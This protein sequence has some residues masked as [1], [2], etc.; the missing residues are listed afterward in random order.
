MIRK[1][2]IASVVLA[3]ALAFTSPSHGQ[4]Y[5]SR[6]VTVVVPWSPGA[7]TDVLA[8]LV[9]EGLRQELGQPFIVD[10][11]AGASGAIGST[12]V[13]FAKPD[14]YTLLMTVS[15]PITTNQFFQKK[16]PF[17]PLKDVVP[18]SM[19]SESALVLAVHP[20]LPVNTIEEFI[21]YARKNPGK[22]SYGTPGIGT[23][24]HIV[25]ETM[26]RDLGIDMVHVPY[27]GAEPAVQALISGVI[28]AAFATVPTVLQLS[29]EGR[30]RIIATTRRTP[31]LDLPDVPP[32]SR[33]LPGFE[34]VSWVGIF[35]PG[36]TPL[37]II[38]KL[39]TAI[40]KIVRKPEISDIMRAN[41]N[42]VVGSTPGDLDKQVRSEI[43]KWGP[44]IKDLGIGEK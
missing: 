38:E 5:P 31:L 23:A 28:P 3:S 18:I 26:K 42:I 43:S 19:V 9:S 40:A 1:V 21:E 4:E 27:R 33:V 13:A 39:T 24:Q 29:K 20:D 7:V 30:L 10:N 44:I 8:R 41:G 16:Y 14:G 11:K 36:G 15:A 37:P 2:G 35:A 22:L 17:N 32:I 34:S 25:G 6:P 12:F